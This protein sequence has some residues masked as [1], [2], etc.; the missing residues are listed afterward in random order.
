MIVDDTNKGAS[1]EDFVSTAAVD[2]V[3]LVIE[4]RDMV[5]DM[6]VLLP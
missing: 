5:V 4:V 2:E 6:A 3:G 1:S